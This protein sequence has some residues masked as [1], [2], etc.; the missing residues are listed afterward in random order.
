MSNVTYLPTP[1]R[2][3]RN[4]LL[5]NETGRPV[6]ARENIE[7]ALRH[8][9]RFRRYAPAG[10]LTG[11]RRRFLAYGLDPTLDLHRLAVMAANEVRF[12]PKRWR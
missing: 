6:P 3:W 11:L 1:K 5:R 2:P 9:K 8:D 4:L 12:N 10:D 7:L